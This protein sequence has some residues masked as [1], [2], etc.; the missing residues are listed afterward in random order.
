MRA[1]PPAL[2]L[3]LALL[4]A[5]GGDDDGAAATQALFDLQSAHDTPP[6]FW[7]LPFPSD[8]RLD[9]DGHPDLT[10][11]YSKG[12]GTL[13]ED[14]RLSAEGR[15]GFAQVPVIY[16]RFDAPLAALD[17]ADVI[18]ADSTSPILLLDIDPDSP[19]QG[20]L[21]PVVATVVPPDD[22][23]PS[24][25]LAV[26]PRPGVVLRA[27]T[28]YAL[29]I[30]RGL[31]DESG[32][33]LGVPGAL[34]AL[35]AGDT[36]D[37]GAGAAT[38]YAPL[39]P[40][41]DR[42]GVP[43][44]DVAAATVFTTGDVVGD[45]ARM[46]DALVAGYSAT[47]DNLHLDPD[48]GAHPDYCEIQLDLTVPQ[49]L[50]GTE[51]W[52]QGGRFEIGTDDLPVM[53]GS[54]TVPAVITVPRAAMP[55][56]G[57]PLLL[58]FHGSGGLHDQVVDASRSP[59]PD[60]D[61]P[62]GEGPAMYFAR[63]GMGSAG[64]ALPVNPER[65]PGASEQAYINLNN[66]GA[67]PY[68]FRQG[69]I[70]QR[71]FL[72]ALTDLEIDPSVLGACT[73]VTLPADQTTIHFDPSQLY[74]GGQSMGGMY[75]NMFGAVD[76][77]PRALVPTGAGGYWSL[78]VLAS[79]KFAGYSGLLATTLGTNQTLS[80]MHPGMHTLEMAWEAAEPV[81]YVPHIGRRP[82]PGRDPRPV[83][84]PVGDDDGYFAEPV[85]DA[86]ALAY[87]NQEAG[88]QVWPTMQDALALAGLD[89]LV[90][91][92][93]V[94]N[95]TSE[96]GEAYTGAVVQYQGDG[97]EDPHAI[98]RQLDQ[99]IYQYSCFLETAI[100]TGHPVVE[101]PEALGTPCAPAP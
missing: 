61:G 85:Y 44:T 50:T 77:R 73:G 65:V 83:Y 92:P 4:P 8:L 62:P 24:Y 55:Q 48:D 31:G 71:L 32:A 87:G 14:L 26:A 76:P 27:D 28:T 20:V 54:R 63:L 75:T 25:L 95:R 18:A 7:D 45:F 93:V 58:Y 67:F 15:R 16:V 80:F 49:F 100:A 41:L 90:A 98:Y 52:D 17:P 64:S 1:L 96:G 39:W 68:L 38:V 74:A 40:A 5:C 101:A 11:F 2:F 69:V 51:P 66:L 82:L 46:S 29:V 97:I 99:V 35:A 42:L 13:G 19:D 86:M 22:F 9:P 78:M 59:A 37:G 79:R 30:R 56:A 47:L 57:F 3:A 91:Y 36:P 6:T 72:S 84:E 89:G 81:V 12:D 70:E 33:P 23:A 88:D 34:A 60:T 10:G 21:A 94:D 53:Q 43:R